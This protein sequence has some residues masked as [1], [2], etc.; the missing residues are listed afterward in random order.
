M[1]FQ[2]THTHTAEACP[3]QSPEQS[4]RVGDWWQALKDNPNVK[5]LSGYVSPIDH[6]FYI[7]IEADDN[8]AL[9][10][11]LGPL[12][13]LGAGNISPVLSLDQTFTIAQEGVFRLQQ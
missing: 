12:N 6:V 13:T 8:T 10:R 11:A 1:L 3:G 5:V 9:A 7:T 2:V 4:K